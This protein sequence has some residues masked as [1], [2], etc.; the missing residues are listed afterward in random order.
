[1]Y[2]PDLYKLQGEGQGR[3]ITITFP[4]G[5]AKQYALADFVDRPLELCGRLVQVCAAASLRSNG[6]R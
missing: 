5:A 6:R 4:D 3:T 2:Y 1:V